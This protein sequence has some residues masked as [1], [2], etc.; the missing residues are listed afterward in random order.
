MRPVVSQSARQPERILD[1]HL[2]GG[3]ANRMIQYMVVRSI[4]AEVE[5]CRI[6][7][8]SLPEW[9]ID[10]PVV[11]GGP[12]PETKV[13]VSRGDVDIAEIVR[14]LSSGE[15]TRV[16]FKSY[17]QWFP[18]FPD[19][20]FCRSIFPSN[21]EE[22]PGFGPEFLVCNVRGGDIL[23]GRFANYVLLPIKF[24]EELVRTTGLKLV[25]TGQIEDNPYCN[26]LR[27]R[28]PA[29]TFHK[30]R[31][32]FADFQTFRNS[33][34]L[35]MAVSTFSWLAAWLSRAEMIVFPMSGIL[36]PIQCPAVDL[37]PY[38]DGRYR[39]YM[40]PNNYAV[41]LDQVKAS[42]EGLEGR[43][44]PLAMEMI[45]KIR[46]SVYRCPGTFLDQF[47]SMFDEEFYLKKNPDVARVV[48]SGRL[49]RGL[50]HYVA[51]GFG[52]GRP[53][54]DFDDGWYR[55]EYPAAAMEVERGKYP[56]LRHHF[57]LV[58]AGLG[59]QPVRNK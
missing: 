57:V 45:P 16:N 29:A 1:V 26:S 28:F 44:Q 19:L 55:A 12:S 2:I 37:I 59:Y 4:A 38:P 48:R 49:A 11:E 21:E 6:S 47:V 17:A 42:H 43:W 25:F 46:A 51:Y 23:D 18:N 34:N 15:E 22:Y 40:F 13:L 58:G 27:Q 54:F 39:F 10:H 8:V 56:D 7:N 31:G 20:D 32:P 30:S 41:P 3:F 9:N 36:N 35:V 33:E 53:G 52:E 24:Y 50:D 14:L 5:G